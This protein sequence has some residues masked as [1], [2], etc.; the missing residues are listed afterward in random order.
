MVCCG[1]VLGLVACS[2]G[3][4]GPRRWECGSDIDC[5]PAAGW[6]CHVPAGWCIFDGRS[7]RDG[8]TARDTGVATE[9]AGGGASDAGEAAPP[10]PDAPL[11]GTEETGEVLPPPPSRGWHEREAWGAEFPTAAVSLDWERH[12]L[13]L[14]QPEGRR[15]EVVDTT[16]APVGRSSLPLPGAPRGLFYDAY[17]DEVLVALATQPMDPEREP[18]EQAGRLGVIDAITGE[19]RRSYELPVDAWSVVADGRGNAFVSSSAAA[20]LVRVELESGAVTLGEGHW[21]AGATMYLHP[22]RAGVYALDAEPHVL[23]AELDTPR[24]L[25]ELSLRPCGGIAMDPRGTRLATACGEVYALGAD[26]RAP[27]RLI[28]TLHGEPE[29]KTG[30]VRAVALHPAGHRVLV[31]WWDA[32]NVG[33]FDTTDGRYTGHLLMD[34]DVDA[35]LVGRTYAVV[36]TQAGELDL[37]AGTVGLQTVDYADFRRDPF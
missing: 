14:A 20:P 10:I 18:S 6:V 24:V 1:V 8:G 22:G 9:D 16:T 27:P 28:A 25:P 32:A 19:L 17:R 30:N 21:P 12:R 13:Y 4:S 31:T 5:D 35:L 36:L 15:V 33:A 37:R 26:V 34:V 29:W 23:R 2:G 11:P 3:E 7:R